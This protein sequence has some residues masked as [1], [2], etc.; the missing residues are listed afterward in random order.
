MLRDRA[1]S[2]LLP[3]LVIAAP[4][5]TLE[6]IRLQKTKITIGRLP[7]QN[8][9]FLPDYDG[10]ITRIEHCLL[11]R[12]QGGWMLK[13]NSTNGTCLERESQKMQVQ[14]LPDREI[15]I[16]SGDI[17][18]IH[19]YQLTFNDPNR[20]DPLQQ[21]KLTQSRFLYKLSQ[22]TLYQ[23]KVGQRTK[24]SLTPQMNK[25]LLCMAR[26]NLD[27]QGDPS[28]CS[29]DE[30]LTEI[31]GKDEYGFT[32]SNVNDLARHVRKLFEDYEGSRTL[33]ETVKTRGYILHIDCES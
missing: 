18:Y 20:T 10:I 5:G 4:D 22:E 29:Y 8:D 31:W 32:V 19:T 24:L 27:H 26:K 1:M 9:I 12:D 28:V 15:E 14:D 25:M 6:T 33:L 3:Y 23:I 7:E 13:D 2:Q 11:E 16:S 21:P 17:I 30:L